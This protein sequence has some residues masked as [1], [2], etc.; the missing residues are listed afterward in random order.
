MRARILERLEFCRRQKSETALR[1][2]EL[3]SE[4]VTKAAEEKRKAADEKAAVKNSLDE[5]LQKRDPSDMVERILNYAWRGNEQG[6]ENAPP[7]VR[8]SGYQWVPEWAFFIK[9]SECLYRGIRFD[10]EGGTIIRRKDTV[11]DLKK[12]DPRLF[13]FKEEKNKDLDVKEYDVIYDGK[14][15]LKS[16]DPFNIE[17]VRRGFSL[18]Y[19]QYCTGS[20]ASF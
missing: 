18:I 6:I 12:Y 13:D 7:S 10:R 1:K 8:P 5:Y 16:Y 2:R 3:A 9:D 14:V 15:L 19:S 17:R 11:L 4:A 20:K